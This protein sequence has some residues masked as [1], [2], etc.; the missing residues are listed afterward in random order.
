MQ[1]RGTHDS[2]QD[3]LDAGHAGSVEEEAAVYSVIMAI[4][5]LRCDMR[6]AV[7][8]EARQGERDCKHH[9]AGLGR[10][11]VPRYA[12]A[13]AHHHTPAKLSPRD[14][15]L[16]WAVPLEGGAATIEAPQ[17]RVACRCIACIAPVRYVEAVRPEA[18]ARLEPT[19]NIADHDR[20]PS[21]SI[22]NRKTRPHY[23]SAA[24]CSLSPS[25][26]IVGTS[27][28]NI[29]ITA[30]GK[31]H[32]WTHLLRRYPRARLVEPK[33]RKDIFAPR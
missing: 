11:R 30:H 2:A 17:V 7:C 3:D 9:R 12:H 21:Y 8:R 22:L 5:A 4:L 25:P 26:A 27:C 29:V 10:E 13:H 15:V 20:M 32:Y 16:C 14:A 33:P 18:Y 24:I 23:L 1:G 19:N 6:T 31:P 28:S